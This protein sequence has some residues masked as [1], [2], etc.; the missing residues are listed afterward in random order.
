[1]SNKLYT[2]DEVAELLRVH[3]ATVRRWIGSGQ[4]HAI[5]LPG[6]NYRITEAELDRLRG[7]PTV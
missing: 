4:V 5:R 3:P 7:V 1:M 6:G 2:P